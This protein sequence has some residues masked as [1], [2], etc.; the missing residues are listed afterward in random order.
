MILVDFTCAT[1]PA[2]LRILVK[3]AIEADGA[4]SNGVDM[5]DLM[6][7]LARHRW[8]MMGPLCPD[9]ADHMRKTTN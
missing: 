9:C 3:N 7:K 5:G 4:V 2:T 1:C 6:D 8:S